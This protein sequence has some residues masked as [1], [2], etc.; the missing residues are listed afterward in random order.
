MLVI[1]ATG[2]ISRALQSQFP[3]SIITSSRNYSTND[4][5]I[6]DLSTIHTDSSEIDRFLQ[7]SKLS[8]VIIAGAMTAVDACETKHTDAIRI[9]AS[10]P[11]LL[12]RICAN[13]GIRTI[14]ISTD[15]VFDGLAGS[16]LETDQPNP[17]SYYGTTKLAGE[18]G[19]S[20][21]N[22]N[23]LI[24]RTTWVYGPDTNAKNFS[25]QVCKSFESRTP[26]MV[27]R[28]QISTPTFNRDLALKIFELSQSTRTG[29]VH[30]AGGQRMSKY[31]FAVALAQSYKIPADLIVP[32]AT[33]ELQQSACRPLLAGLKSHEQANIVRPF[34]RKPL[35]VD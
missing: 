19:V 4:G 7:K 17:I 33:K 13:Y 20:K 22:S 2:Q 16:Y 26:L 34:L 21:E 30:V 11:R 35:P 5:P 1:G 3:E 25:S 14:Y 27:P 23:S 32:V 31:E 10:G 28:D 15:Y 24:I 18:V 12:A 8:S 6:V 29:I 9:N